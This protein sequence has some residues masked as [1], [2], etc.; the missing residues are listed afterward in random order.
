MF[1]CVDAQVVHYL[2]AIT[3]HLWKRWAGEDIVSESHKKQSTAY[4]EL[5]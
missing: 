5:N 4:N 3:K 2:A 1:H